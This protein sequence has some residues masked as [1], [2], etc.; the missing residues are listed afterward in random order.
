MHQGPSSSQLPI[1]LIPAERYSGPE[2]PKVVFFGFIPI[3]VWLGEHLIVQRAYF[4]NSYHLLP[5]YFQQNNL[6]V[7][8][9]NCEGVMLITYIDVKGNLLGVRPPHS[10]GM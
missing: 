3:E 9:A 8:H 1:G 2:I 5:E 6:L 7:R 10:L 4:Q